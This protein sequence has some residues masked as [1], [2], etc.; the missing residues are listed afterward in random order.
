MNTILNLIS[1][2]VSKMTVYIDSN[3]F[4]FAVLG[5]DAR[6]VKAKDLLRRINSGELD[7]VTST[8]A[9]DEVVWVVWKETKDRAL[10]IRQG[11][12]IF[13]FDNLKIIGTDNQIMKNA[14]NFMKQ[15]SSFKMRDAIH[16]AT[17]QSQGVQTIITDDDDF[18]AVKDIKRKSLR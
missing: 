7:A 9:I 2:N 13:E 8:L 15:H 16:L 10:A 17:A 4:I 11:L 14:L 6:A 3:I 1:G 12:N 5:D 18:D